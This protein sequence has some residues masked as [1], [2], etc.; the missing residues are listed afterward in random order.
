LSKNIS[1]V[2]GKFLYFILRLKILCSFS[3]QTD[4]YDETQNVKG[5]LVCRI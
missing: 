4:G 3:V 2:G 1:I 5:V